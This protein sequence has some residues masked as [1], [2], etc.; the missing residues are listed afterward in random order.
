[1]TDVHP[2]RNGFTPFQYA[3][4]LGRVEILRA[5]IEANTVPPTEV[6]TSLHAVKEKKIEPL[7][8]V[9]TEARSRMYLH[10]AIRA[11]D[12]HKVRHAHSCILS[13]AH[14]RFALLE[15]FLNVCE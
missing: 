14:N 12:Q 10:H 6:V 11:N 9:L 8:A 2:K 1:M 15:K 3:V 13:Y 4:Q 5:L 7:I